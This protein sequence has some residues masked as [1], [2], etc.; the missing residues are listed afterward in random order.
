MAALVEEF[1]KIDEADLAP[2]PMEIEQ[3]ILEKLTV[4]SDEKLS[5]ILI[6]LLA[7]AASKSQSHLAHPS[8]ITVAENLSP[9]EAVILSSLVD[10]KF[11]M[12]M[13]DASFV[14]I[15]PERKNATSVAAKYYSELKDLALV[16]PQNIDFYIGCL[17]Y[18]SPSPR[19]R[20]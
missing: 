12:P 18:T 10:P 15:R 11:R 5:D 1:K 6:K 19:D 14:D 8:M 4:A 9:D 17:L 2:A 7:A 3:P 20:G 16:N 13:I